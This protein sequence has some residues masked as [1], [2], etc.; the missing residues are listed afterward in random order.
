[1]GIRRECWESGLASV[2]NPLQIC[3]PALVIWKLERVGRKWYH[4]VVDEVCF[5]NLRL[6]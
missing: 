1:M 6:L 2:G 3:P 4:S 5:K